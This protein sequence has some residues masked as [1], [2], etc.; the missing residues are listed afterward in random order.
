MLVWRIFTEQE[1]KVAR[2]ERRVKDDCGNTRS[3]CIVCVR[4]YTYVCVCVCVGGEGE[5]E[6]ERLLKIQ[7]LCPQARHGFVPQFSPPKQ[8][9]IYKRPRE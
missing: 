3:V 8:I 7:R 5:R 9:S 6:R 4:V 1:A 2:E